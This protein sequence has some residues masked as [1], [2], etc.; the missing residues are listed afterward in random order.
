[1]ANST[2]S[3][4]SKGARR[5]LFSRK[6]KAEK[7]NK[8]PGRMK[9]IADVFK[10]TRRNDP[11][12]IWRMVGAFV[13]II[14]I[15][16]I[17]GFLIDNWVTMLII[18]IP[19]GLLAAMFI[20]S[21]R[22][23]RAAFAQIEGQPGASGA[24][25]SV[26][27]RGWILEEQPV[28]VSP[29][30]QDAVFRAIG[31]PG[32]VLVTEGPS[33]RV[34][35]LV[36]GE[37]RKM[38]R[39]VPNVP[40]HVIQ[41][42]RGEGQVPAA[43]GG[44][45]GQEAQ[46]VADQA[47]GPGREQAPLRHRPAPADP[48]GNRPVQGTPGPQGRTRPL[49]R[50]QKERPRQI[51]R[52]RSFALRGRSASVLDLHEDGLHGTVVQAA[53]VG[54]EYQGRDD[55]AQQD[56]ADDAGKGA[57]CPAVQFLDLQAEDAVADAVA[58]QANE[59]DLLCGEHQQDRVAGAAEEGVGNERGHAQSMTR[60]PSRGPTRAMEPGPVRGLPSLRPGQLPS[61]DGGPSSHEPKLLLS[62]T[63]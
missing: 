21:R 51:C 14:A 17:I 23:E 22:A 60:A 63:V 35:A 4:A 24:A 7:K 12:V 1:M 19:L 54:V 5:G 56:S 38:N 57:G 37:R 36:D 10:M 13:G 41:T 26:L 52:G 46:E 42:G 58:Q 45:E 39:I 33:N 28:A 18:A 2:D 3:D 40:V 31:R 53:L 59:Q 55:Q 16:L 32:I 29:R 50:S 11:S 62:T 49:S 8:Q 9:Q 30:T 25:L 34:K 43:A 44:Q 47:G 15:G 61:S 20:L 48:Q 27:R 6:P